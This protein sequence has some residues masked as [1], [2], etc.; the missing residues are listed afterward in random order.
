[1]LLFCCKC[2]SNQQYA[3]YMTSQHWIG[4]CVQ[5]MPRGLFSC[6]SVT[7]SLNQFFF[8]VFQVLRIVVF[9]RKFSFT[10]NH[11][12]KP[13]IQVCNDLSINYDRIFIFGLTIPLRIDIGFCFFNLCSHITSKHCIY[14]FIYDYYYFTF[15]LHF[16][17]M[18]R[19]W[20]FFKSSMPAATSCAVHLK[21]STFCSHVRKI[22]QKSVCISEDVPDR[23][24]SC[25]RFW[26]LWHGPLLTT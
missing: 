10:H 16:L 25:W 9:V 1:M 13:V 20:K 2:P 12:S 24:I 21:T 23:I 5:Y 18:S 11:T 14:L 3:C 8:F 4:N 26:H 17:N 22:L 15:L 7:A 19:H 6:C